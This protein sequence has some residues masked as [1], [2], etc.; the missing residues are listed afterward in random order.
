MVEIISIEKNPD[1]QGRAHGL[2]AKKSVNIQKETVLNKPLSLKEDS[3]DLSDKLQKK[4]EQKH[5]L[6]PKAQS[7]TPK[8]TT[9]IA[10]R[11]WNG[12]SFVSLAGVIFMFL[13]VVMNFSSYQMILEKRIGDFFGWNDNSQLERLAQDRNV[14]QD[15]IPN[16]NSGAISERIA[17]VNLDV[18]PPDTRILIPRINKNVPVIPVSPKNLIRR[19]WSALENDIQEALRSGVVHYPGTSLPGES[20]NTVITGHSSYFPWDPGRF[21]DVFALLHDLQVNDRVVVYYNQQKFI[22]EIKTIKVVMPEQVEVL[23]QGDTEK[24]TL[25]TCTPIGTNLKRLIIEAYP[26]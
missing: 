17:T 25:L 20:G 14:I 12:L 11:V 13:F 10:D 8:K 2:Q 4:K 3:F 26:I 23:N 22:Y 15:L 24:L 9:S 6:K 5:D 19:D 7:D 18:T 21:K 16:S 1:D